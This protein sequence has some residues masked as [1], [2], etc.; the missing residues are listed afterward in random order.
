MKAR[1]AIGWTPHK[2]RLEP[3]EAAELLLRTDDDV[4][5]Q[6][7]WGVLRSMMKDDEYKSKVLSYAE[8]KIMSTSRGL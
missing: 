8:V 1:R 4:D 5:F 3:K 2:P 7:A 6:A